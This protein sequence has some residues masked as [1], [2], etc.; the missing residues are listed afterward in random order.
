MAFPSE[1]KMEIGSVGVG[2]F[3]AQAVHVTTGNMLA[4]VCAIGGKIFLDVHPRGA[5]VIMR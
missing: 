1:T 3:R 4:G 2:A 5:V